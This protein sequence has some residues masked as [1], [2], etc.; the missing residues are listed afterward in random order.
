[1]STS[2]ERTWRRLRTTLAA[3]RPENDR[4]P[5]AERKSVE[6]LQELYTVAVGLSLT[7]GIERL[8][9]SELHGGLKGSTIAA[10]VAFMA[11]LLPFYHGALRHLDRSYLQGGQ[12]RGGGG[13]LFA[14]FFA[15]F[16]E[17]CV[18]I[19]MAASLERPHRFLVLFLLLLILDIVW[20][21]FYVRLAAPV[22]NP[23]NRSVTWADRAWVLVNTPFLFLGGTILAAGSAF[24]SPTFVYF[25][26]ALAVARTACDY[27]WSWNFYFP[28]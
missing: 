15:L 24:P 11:T 26:C 10:F 5:D 25:V 21:E 7:V 1:M 19:A 17:A 14:D 22:I 3:A 8:F 13:Y 20:L 16:A 18:F 23:G 9:P 2:P 12:S 4:Q 28:T 6:H 27:A